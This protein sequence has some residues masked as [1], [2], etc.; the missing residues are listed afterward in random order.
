M[1][2]LKASNEWLEYFKKCFG[3]RQ[4]RIVGEAED[5]PV[6]II[7]ARMERLPEIIQGY[8]ADDIWNMDESGLF[9]KA[10][11]NTGSAK[12]TKKCKDGKK[13]KSDLLWHF[14]FTQVDS[15][16]VNLLLNFRV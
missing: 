3:L 6:I 8:S 9:F 2:N 14:L 1:G 12:K 16:Y 13:S 5:V 15:R 7:K 4:T 11:P 10:F